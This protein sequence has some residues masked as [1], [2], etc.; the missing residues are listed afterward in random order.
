MRKLAENT[1]KSLSE[2]NASVNVIVQSISDASDAVEKNAESALQLVSIS[3]EVQASLH[4]VNE[5]TSITHQNSLDDTENS[6]IIKTEAH[7]SKELATEQIQRFNQT[8]KVLEEMKNSIAIV[9]RTT[10]TLVEQISN[11]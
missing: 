7:E 3:D 1:Q 2:I 8:S 9:D 10:K 5:V 11:I 6:E 4:E